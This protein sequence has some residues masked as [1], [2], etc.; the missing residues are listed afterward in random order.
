MLIPGF[1]VFRRAPHQPLRQLFGVQLAAAL[2]GGDFPGHDLLDQVQSGAA[3]AIG[4]L[5]Q[6]FARLAG[7]RQGAA[8][9][10]FGTLRQ[11]LQI[12]KA[13]ALE[14]DDLRARQ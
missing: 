10:L 11:K 6:P 13:Q 12:G 8:K 2:L 1:V 14:H 3:I 9:L 4:H 5:Q 7:Q